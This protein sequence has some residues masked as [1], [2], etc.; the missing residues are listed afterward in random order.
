MKTFRVRVPFDGE[1]VIDIAA[2]NEKA[3]EK[4]AGVI[5]NEICLDPRT[6]KH[7][8]ILDVDEF[9]DVGIVECDLVGGG[10]S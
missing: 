3:A 10:E 9:F 8:K 6:W 2:P 7:S 5:V 4:L 1:V